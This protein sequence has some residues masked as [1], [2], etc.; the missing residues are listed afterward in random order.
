M[1]YRI[2]VIVFAFML[3]GATASLAAGPFTGMFSS[4]LT[5]APLQTIPI[6]AFHSRL[7]TT[8]SLGVLSAS[9]RSD[10]TV[11]NWLWQ[12]FSIG[13]NVSFFSTEVNLLFD[14]DP[15]AF[16]YA[17]GIASITLGPTFFNYS[18]AFLGPLYTGTVLRGA[19]LEAGVS[20]PYVTI[21]ST[22][23]FGA[24]DDGLLFRPQ[25]SSIAC[26][27]GSRITPSLQERYYK[28]R[29]FLDDCITFT[30]EEF[31]IEGCLCGYAS[32]TA[33]TVIQ[34]AGFTSQSFVLDIQSLAGLPLNLTMTTVIDLT[35][36]SVTLAPEIAGIGTP[37]YGLHFMA[38]LLTQ[39]GG[40]VVTG[41]S[42]YGLDMY[43]IADTFGI[44]SLS[45]LDT[46]THSL[47]E[48]PGLDLADSFW[49]AKKNYAGVCGHAGMELESW[50]LLA[51][52]ASQGMQGPGFSFVAATFFN[53]STTTSFEW[54]K[55][56][57]RAQVNVMPNL[58]LRSTVTV[59]S[60]GLSSW[61]LGVD[62]SW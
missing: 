24:D 17:S 25:T 40:F 45:V 48:S 12:S 15:W 21:R 33:T 58:S 13:I 62:I 51:I 19:I 27:E 49:I 47:Y 35:S 14:A 39:P 59:A 29:P 52:S 4:D 10:F 8:L 1:T 23:Y 7:D 54:R 53:H 32:L 5:L 26:T 20:Y 38:D 46:A 57:F 50:E 28:V 56:E 31:T 37:G 61:K 3:L 6:S 22:T 18:M 41:V 16:R 44:R 11:T 2:I 36:Q 60:H 34:T 9:S 43:M 30:K 55:T 42:V